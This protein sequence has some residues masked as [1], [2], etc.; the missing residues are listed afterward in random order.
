MVINFTVTCGILLTGDS[1]FR[2]R[3]TDFGGLKGDQYI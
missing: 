2:P 1:K 3:S